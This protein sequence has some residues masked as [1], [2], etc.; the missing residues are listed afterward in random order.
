MSIENTLK[1]A[2]KR[3]TLEFVPAE[4]KPL[5]R[6]A[7]D[8]LNFFY[9]GTNPGAVNVTDKF[10][11]GFT[12]ENLQAAKAILQKNTLA[13]DEVDVILIDLP[14]NKGEFTL[15]QQFILSSPGLASVPVI[16]NKQQEK[17]NCAQLKQ[18]RFIDDVIDLNHWQIN[19]SRKLAFLK[20]AKAHQS[21]LALK[22]EIWITPDFKK[23]NLKKETNYLFKRILDIL[24]ASF[25]LVLLSP[26]FL[27]IA[28]AIK[29][30]SKGPVF[31]NSF[32]AGRG[33][34]VF[35]FYKFRTMEMN[36]DKKIHALSHLN[37][38]SSGGEAIFFK[39]KDDPRIT[40]LGAFLRNTSLDE[41]PQLFNVIK[42]DMSLVGNRPLPL[43]EAAMLTTNE[44]VERFMAPAGITGLWQ[45][46][47]RGKSDMS[48]EERI[49]LDI[50]YAR[51]SNLF[52][53]LWI[54]ANTPS[55]LFQKSNV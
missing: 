52:Y 39:I 12:A 35:K 46:K 29:I 9:I 40:K 20:K 33:Y 24:V 38:Y 50:S 13:A 21:A 22:R 36:A 28:I 2:V 53:D 49:S 6:V 11:I 34:K 41:L 45:I 37:Q 1:L 47:K 3:Q 7:Q 26:L 8:T 43:Y 42:G 16:Y 48:V 15:F 18:C 5:V 23:Y 27:I 51:K 25:I 14:Y 54:M 4:T 31:Y 30:G 17:N 55:A 44:S 19:F 32:R 10:E